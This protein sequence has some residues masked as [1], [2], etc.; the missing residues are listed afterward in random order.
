MKTIILTLLA[1]LTTLAAVG[2]G[3]YYYRVRAAAP[4]ASG[5]VIRDRSDS[6]T[7]GCGCTTTLAKQAL[8]DRNLT[9]GSMLTVIATGDR[10]TAD[11]PTLIAGYDVPA[12]RQAIE[13]RNAM[14]R[15]RQELLTDLQSKCEQ[16]SV[17]DRSPIVL[18]VKRA[19]ERLR[20]SGC[21]NESGCFVYVQSDGQETAEPA[22]RQLLASRSMDD[23]SPSLLLIDND[24]IDVV[25]Y[26]LSDTRG[27][28]L[29]T[30]RR[31][32]ITRT[33]GADRADHLRAVWL[34]LVK[35]PER[36]SFEPFCPK[37]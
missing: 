12:T 36:V 19:I 15:K 25:F 7:S 20:A 37:D 23:R 3:L 9:K 28:E 31:R 10:A 33:R 14:L 34:S 16:L 2:V 5:V 24:G 35:H 18:A 27:E 21:R 13:G 32:L 6:V 30:G 17:T 4:A 8:R 26:G 22:I 29:S 1:F 11:E